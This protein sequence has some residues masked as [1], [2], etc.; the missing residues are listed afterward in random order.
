MDELS[1]LSLYRPL[2]RCKSF[3]R[4]G[5]IIIRYTQTSE[6][7]NH[8]PKA[9]KR[10]LESPVWLGI[11]EEKTQSLTESIRMAGETGP[12]I[13]ARMNVPDL[14]HLAPG[15][16]ICD[17]DRLVVAPLEVLRQIRF[18]LPDCIIAVCTSL[19]ERT[20]IL[21]C[22][23]AGANCVLSQRSTDMETSFGIR[24]VLKFGCFTDPYFTAA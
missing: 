24:T 16:M 8:V 20:W 22:H 14:A 13:Q 21:A 23:V 19:S 3:D 10:C 12:I 18:V 1:V 11:M 5:S 2:S 4:D 15:F 6:A 9:L 17:I 7:T